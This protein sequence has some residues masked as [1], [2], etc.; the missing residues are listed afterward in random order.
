LLKSGNELLERLKADPHNRLVRQEIEVAKRAMEGI[1]K[2]LRR[3]ANSLQRDLAP[4]MAVVDKLAVSVRRFGEADQRDTLKRAIGMIIDNVRELY[5]AQPALPAKDVIDAAVWEKAAAFEIDQA[6]EFY[7]AYALA[8]YQAMRALD[9]MTMAVSPTPPVTPEEVTH[10]ANE[11]VG[12]RAK[13]IA[14]RFA[15]G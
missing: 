14:A 9:M 15:S 13:A 6:A 1:Q 10:R 11:S 3:G 5:R 7:E 2:T 12:A 8:G 4:S